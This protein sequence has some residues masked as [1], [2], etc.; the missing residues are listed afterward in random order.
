MLQAKAHAPTPSPFNIFTFGLTVDSIKE[1]GGVSLGTNFAHLQLWAIHAFLVH[2]YKKSSYNFPSPQCGQ[3]SADHY[4]IPT[5][6]WEFMELVPLL[7]QRILL[8]P[9]YL[10]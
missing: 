8:W 2:L 9:H 4:L 6:E 1:L 3:R 10:S 5:L 7:L